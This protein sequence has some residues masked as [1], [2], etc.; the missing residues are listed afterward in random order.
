VEPPAE[1]ENDYRPKSSF[2]PFS[3][4]GI[5]LPGIYTLIAHDS[6]I[7]TRIQDHLDE[8]EEFKV[9][10]QRTQELLSG[11]LVTLYRLVLVVVWDA[12]V[13]AFLTS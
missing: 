12:L 7:R 3:W 2:T 1:V 11:W 5:Y 10:T 6:P 13:C 9:H 4:E 8:V